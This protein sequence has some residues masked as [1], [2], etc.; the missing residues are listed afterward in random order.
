MTL[1]K[2][3]RTRSIAG[4]NARRFKPVLY[5]EEL[6]DRIHKSLDDSGW[7]LKCGEWAQAVEPDARAYTCEMCGFET[8]Y[9]LEELVMMELV[10]IIPS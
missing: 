1:R 3:Y 2:E 7:C 4:S 6:M 8:V 5:A 9:G 10:E